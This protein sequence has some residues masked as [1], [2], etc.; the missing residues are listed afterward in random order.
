VLGVV[1]V[2]VD[3][4]GNRD[5]GHLRE[6]YLL[7]LVDDRFGGSV[8]WLSAHGLSD[9]D[10]ERLRRRLAPAER[11]VGLATFAAAAVELSLSYGLWQSWWIATLWLTSFVV[12]LLRDAPEAEARNGDAET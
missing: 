11:A 6:H 10:L 5:H 7:E 12:V 2:P 8:A 3:L 1:L 4:L 9:A